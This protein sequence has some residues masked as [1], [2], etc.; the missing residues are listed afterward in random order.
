[1][2]FSGFLKIEICVPFLAGCSFLFRNILTALARERQ[3]KAIFSIANLILN[4]VRGEF[5]SPH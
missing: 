5:Y 3:K 4:F 2:S 1:M